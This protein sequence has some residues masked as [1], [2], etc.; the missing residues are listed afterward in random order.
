MSLND[1]LKGLAVERL[2]VMSSSSSEK[3]EFREQRVRLV[4]SY[5]KFS[6]K[7]ICQKRIPP[8]C[9]TTTINGKSAVALLSTVTRSCSKKEF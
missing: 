1:I 9:L 6:V 7:G 8:F 2:T 4:L 5:S 3:S